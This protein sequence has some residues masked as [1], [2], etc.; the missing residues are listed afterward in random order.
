M[1]PGAQGCQPAASDDVHIHA[2]VFHLHEL[3]GEF[4]LSIVSYIVTAKYTK[5]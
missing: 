2:D 4:I 1:L 5:L 3:P